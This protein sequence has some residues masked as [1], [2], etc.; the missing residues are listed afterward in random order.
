VKARRDTVVITLKKVLI[1]EYQSMMTLF[2]I[3]NAQLT[4]DETC[5]YFKLC[6]VENLQKL[7]MRLNVGLSHGTSRTMEPNVV[8][9]S[10]IKT[11]K[12]HHIDFLINC[13]RTIN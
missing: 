9:P 8:F 4:F 10:P 6:R 11:T 1:L 5:E 7:Q 13:L 3:P 12:Q 2:M